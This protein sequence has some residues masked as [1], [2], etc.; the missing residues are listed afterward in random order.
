V[1]HLQ[2]QWQRDKQEFGVAAAAEATLPFVP[3]A[4]W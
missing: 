4:K 1:R 2:Q 3:L